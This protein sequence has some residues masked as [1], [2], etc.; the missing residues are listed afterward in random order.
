MITTGQL[1]YVWVIRV[2]EWP[3]A[4]SFI[5]FPKGHTM[6][7]IGTI[8]LSTSDDYN[9][10]NDVLTLETALPVTDFFY[11][12]RCI[13]RIR[14]SDGETVEEIANDPGPET[15]C[16]LLRYSVCCRTEKCS[17]FTLDKS[18]KCWKHCEA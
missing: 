18:K 14:I 6:K 5:H 1:Y 2:K 7:T 16:E 17:V 10:E 13:L 3:E 12:D 4:T 9:N 8:K 11:D 15:E